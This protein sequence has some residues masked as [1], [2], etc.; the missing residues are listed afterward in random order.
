MTAQ[1]SLRTTTST[2][3]HPWSSNTSGV[4]NWAITPSTP[5][6]TRHATRRLWFTDP[7]GTHRP[8]ARGVRVD[9]GDA[10]TGRLRRHRRRR[11]GERLVPGHQDRVCSRPD[12]NRTRYDA[13][14]P[15]RLQSGVGESL[16][17][18]PCTRCRLTGT[19]HTNPILAGVSCFDA[20]RLRF[21]RFPSEFLR[22]CFRWSSS[23][24]AK[25]FSPLGAPSTP[26][27]SLGR[28][29]LPAWSP[30]LPR[31]RHRSKTWSFC[32]KC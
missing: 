11:L 12:R 24:H 5:R 23:F 29:R 1:A 8:S 27:L 14:A 6:R 18:L 16:N 7:Y 30:G 4:A 21:S 26:S 2:S 9:R 32:E 19:I 15:D 13:H 17:R 22:R 28:A 3:V 25:A 10:I 31:K 20:E